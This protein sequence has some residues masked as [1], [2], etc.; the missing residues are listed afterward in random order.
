MAIVGSTIF[1]Q[2]MFGK[3]IDKQM[4]A[5]IEHQNTGSYSE[6]RV[7]NID[8]KLLAFQEEKDSFG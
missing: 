4:A 5:T 1:D 2:T 7:S 3:D 8:G 6:E